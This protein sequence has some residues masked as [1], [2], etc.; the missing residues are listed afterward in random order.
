MPK[1]Y[2]TQDAV[3]ADERDDYVEHEGK[4][5]LKAVVELGKEQAKRA[6]LLSEK[7]EA[8]RLRKEAEQRADELQRAKDAAAS[9]ISEAKLQEI[10]DAERLARKPIED[11]RDTL[12]AENKRLKRDD[13]VRVLYLS[14]KVGGMADRVEDVMDQILKRVELGDNGGLVFKDEKGQV[15]ADDAETF[16]KKFRVEKPFYFKGSGASGSGAEGSNGAGGNQ[17]APTDQGALELKRQQ[18]QGAF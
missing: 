16:F 14:E 2:D 10:R 5:H 4:W 15:T 6:Q 9:G 1:I 17:T 18:L 12:A 11:E 8:D 13:K 7:K 3:P